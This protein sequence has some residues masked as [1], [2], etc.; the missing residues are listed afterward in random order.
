M[1][2]VVVAGSVTTAGP[3]ITTSASPTGMGIGSSR[4]IG[5]GRP[6]KLP[7]GGRGSSLPDGFLS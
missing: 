4:G 5:M 3:P 2:V 1:V 6:K 7:S